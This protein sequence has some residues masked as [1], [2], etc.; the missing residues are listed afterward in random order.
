MTR[1]FQGSPSSNSSKRAFSALA[2]KEGAGSGE[3][4][5]PALTAP[6]D[7]IGGDPSPPPA[8]PGA[9][10]PPPTP[11][12]AP[13]APTAP[14]EEEPPPDRAFRRRGLGGARSRGR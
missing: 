4:F 12:P 1:D 3:R 8:P 7:R 11:F 14:G 13:A 6:S 5:P 9:T 10:P 2:G